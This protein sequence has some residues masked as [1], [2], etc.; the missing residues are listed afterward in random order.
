MLGGESW[1]ARA[2]MAFAISSCTAH[3]NAMF[4][5]SVHRRDP[6]PHVEYIV[7]VRL[8]DLRPVPSHPMPGSGGGG[9]E[10][11]AAAKGAADAAP[12]SRRRR[13][14]VVQVTVRR[15]YREFKAL[16]A[17]NDAWHP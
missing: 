12:P 9:G 13:P 15:R 7:R 11:G 8:R 1:T 6:K 17:R 3:T 16:H 5:L 14:P 10:E 2:A 4:R